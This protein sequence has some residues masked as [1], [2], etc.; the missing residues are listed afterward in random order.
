MKTEDILKSESFL[1]LN[2]LIDEKAEQLNAL[3]LGFQAYCYGVSEEKKMVPVRTRVFE[4]CSG[5]QPSEIPFVSRYFDALEQQMT[6]IRQ[7]EEEIRKLQVAKLR[8]LNDYDYT[9]GDDTFQKR[10]F[11]LE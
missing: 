3:A 9:H 2:S 1:L 5:Q 7:L 11:R 4:E 8:L 10:V 6:Q